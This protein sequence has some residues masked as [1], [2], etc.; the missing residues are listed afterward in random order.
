[1]TEKEEADIFN[2]DNIPQSTWFKFEKVGDRVSGIVTEIYDKEGSNNLPDQKVY[3]LKQ[4]DGSEVSVGIKKQNK[5]IVQR[6]S[7]VVPGDKVGFKFEKEIPAK[8]KGYSAA[9]SIT[10]YV[11]YTPEGDEIRKDKNAFGF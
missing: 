7:K 8:V 9:K 1:M 11:Q 4:E 3:V 10:P 6:L 2:E 5:F